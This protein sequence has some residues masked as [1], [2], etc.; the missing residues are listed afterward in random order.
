MV[1]RGRKCMFCI[2]ILTVG[3][4]VVVV[5][6]VSLAR[7]I[8]ITLPTPISPPHPGSAVPPQ[9]TV[10]HPFLFHCCWKSVEVTV[11]RV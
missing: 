8:Q 1:V 3:I 9:Y 5:Y 11:T 7:P 4:V 2:M 10:L 6:S